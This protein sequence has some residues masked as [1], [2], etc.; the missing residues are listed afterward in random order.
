M[1]YISKT[2]TPNKKLNMRNV[3]FR[4]KI[5]KK[6]PSFYILHYIF[7]SVKWRTSLS[8]EFSTTSFAK[9]NE[10]NLFFGPHDASFVTMNHPLKV[11][12][13]LNNATLKLP[14]LLGGP[15]S[16]WEKN[17]DVIACMHAMKSQFFLWELNQPNLF[18]T[19][20]AKF[21][22]SRRQ[23]LQLSSLNEKKKEKKK[24]N[25]QKQQQ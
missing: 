16:N 4:A 11:I 3:C 20:S 19:V 12:S 25:K 21:S 5:D 8:E 15:T 17:W 1:L 22:P 2:G 10:I 7:C 6:P 9:N 24:Q 13:R 23:Y 14:W 18:E